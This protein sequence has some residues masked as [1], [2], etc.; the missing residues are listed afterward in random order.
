[1]SAPDPALSVP[2]W[3]RTSLE[4]KRAVT[5]HPRVYVYAAWT[6]LAVIVSCLMGKDMLWDTLAYHFYAGFSAIHDRLGRDYF[7]AGSQSY[8]NPYV[9]APFYA[10][11]RTGL[12]AVCVASLLAVA[13]SAILWLTYELTLVV[14]PAD[15]LR[16]RELAA[17][18]AVLLAISNPIL[19]NQLGTS[20][21]DITTAEIV[22]AGWL[23]LVQAVGTPSMA[24]IL[25]AGMLLGAASALKLTNALHALSAYVLL[26]FIPLAWRGKLRIG[27]AFTAALIFGFAVIAL[28]WSI[29]LEHHFGNPFFPLLNDIFRS[30]QFPTA[31]TMD[32]RFV[33][34]SFAAALWRPFKISVPV[35]MV[36]DEFSS[37]DL[38]YALLLVLAVV[39]AGRWLWRKSRRVSGLD[40]APPRVASKRGLTAL[41]SAFLLDW[42]LWLRVSGNGRYFLAMACVAGVL[43]VVLAFRMLEKRPKALA[44]L[45]LA[46][47]S[48]QG[49]QLVFGTGYRLPVAWDAG[50]W[51]EVS[52]PPALRDQPALYFTVGEQS[53]SFIAPFL[54]KGSAAV[55]LGGDYVL[56]PGGANGARVEALIRE[57]SPHIRVISQ[58]DTFYVRHPTGLPDVE[59][60]DD[61]LAAFGL[62]ANPADC[63]TI[64]VRNMSY[65]WRKVLPGTLPIAISQI[66]ARII[67]VPVSPNGE[68]VACSVVHDTESRVALANAERVPDL[69]FARIED[70]CPRLFQPRRPV[71]QVY[72]DSRSGYIWMRKYPSTNLT[73]LIVRGETKLVDGVRGGLPNYLGSESDWA[74]SA[75][76]LVCGRRGEFY[77]ARRF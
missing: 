3:R 42:V 68:F 2:L 12:P 16:L 70:A 43:V 7:A 29:R 45:L 19:I 5:K 50:P 26:V 51:F 24:R 52:V 22:L 23:L 53:N 69:V 49:L 27:L 76:P 75:L 66:K 47:F 39:L 9:Y 10:L 40:A 33:P 58:G 48:I 8:L 65:K 64:A 21:A 41:G 31:P 61:T 36:D 38:R 11:A 37:P 72:G 63:A 60:V 55:N 13:Q 57:Y 28:P 35:T 25:C 54:P 17:A 6:A 14:G 74:K 44:Y 71:T 59:H 73:M 1:M 77:Y 15:N 46:V 30:P 32:S 18:C 56:G 67:R 62:R 4:L 20:Y 34:D